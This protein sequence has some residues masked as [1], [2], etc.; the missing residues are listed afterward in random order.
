[1]VRGHKIYGVCCLKWKLII[2]IT[3]LNFCVDGMVKGCTVEERELV[4]KALAEEA[5]NLQLTVHI[6]S[7]SK[8]MTDDLSQKIQ[9]I[10]APRTSTTD[11]DAVMRETFDKLESDTARDELLRQLR[12]RLLASAARE[13]DCNKILVADT[14]FDLAV[15]VLGDVS[16]GRGSQLVCNVGFSDTR[17]TDVT[18]LR[19]LR[20]FTGEEVVGYLQCYDL[21]PILAS[22][23]YNRSVPASIRSIAKSFVYR[24]DNEFYGTVSTIY[25]T[26]EKLARKT[27]EIKRIN[28]E[29]NT[30][31]NNCCI[32]C[33][34]TL[35]P[36]YTREERLS[37]VQARTFSKLVSTSVG[38]SSNILL[39]SSDVRGQLKDERMESGDQSEKEKCRCNGTA[40][41][42]PRSRTLQPE[43]IEKYFCYG[44]RLIFL[45]SNQTFSV[46]P[47]F[48]LNKIY[49][50]LQM[51]DL[52]QK[53]SDFLL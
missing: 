38:C 44:C 21:D 17:S 42:S 30:A 43:I 1:M 37:V 52:R 49:E 22:L 46:L 14:S 28:T 11:D 2:C 23:K 20:D 25:R 34:L 48:L 50:E 7:L 10:N 13:L 6:V 19:P 27:E 12:R 51:R 18:F 9:L 8:C 24:L 45:S 16:T 36:G 40:C 41:I 53:I 32:L 35:D 15:K 26:S 4:R 3:Y 5:E 33:E 31:V 29:M 39:N 47:T